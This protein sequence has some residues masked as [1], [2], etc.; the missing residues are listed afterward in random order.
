MK[1]II[2]L[3]AVMVVSAYATTSTV[4]SVAGT[5]ELKKDGDTYRGVLRENGISEGYINGKKYE[6]GKWR[7]S[8]EGEMF[9]EACIENP[10]HTPCIFEYVYLARP[11]AVIDNISVHKSRMRMGEA[12]AEKLN[13]LKPDHDIDVVIPIPESSTT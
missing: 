1:N 5:Y 9:R 3:I 6:E 13:K 2:L 8:K 10:I 4:K 12:L 7:I 11:D